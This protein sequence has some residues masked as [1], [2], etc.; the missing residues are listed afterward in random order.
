MGGSAGSGG[1]GG[2]AG[3]NA[4][5]GGG[6]GGTEPTCNTLEASAPEFP[7]YMVPDPMPAGLGGTILDGTYFATSETW[8][9]SPLTET[10]M[11]PGNRTDI[12]GTT[13]QEIDGSPDGVEPLSS[14]LGS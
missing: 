8:Y 3:T 9:E 5:G 13:W 7:L 14:T 10:L 6:S 4:T 11:M 12:A 2:S 1:T